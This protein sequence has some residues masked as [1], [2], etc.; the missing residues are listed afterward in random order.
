MKITVLAAA[1]LVHQDLLQAQ[2]VVLLVKTHQVWRL[3]DPPAKV[4]AWRG[5][6]LPLG[7]REGPP[8]TRQHVR[9][10]HQFLPQTGGRVVDVSAH[11]A[12]EAQT[13][14]VHPACF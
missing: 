6:V 5:A 10:C 14:R 3:R 1:F 7:V 9:V 4:D 2:G 12:D 11:N 8:E 13:P